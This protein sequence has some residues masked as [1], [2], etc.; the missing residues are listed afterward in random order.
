VTGVHI[1]G[2][3]REGGGTSPRWTTATRP[4]STRYTREFKPGH[5]GR[6]KPAKA[7]E[8]Q[9]WQRFF[10]VGP[11]RPLQMKAYFLSIHTHM[12]PSN[13]KKYKSNWALCKSIANGFLCLLKSHERTSGL[14]L[15]C[16]WKGKGTS[17]SHIMFAG[18]T[19]KS[20]HYV[21][22]Y[23]IQMFF[24]IGWPLQPI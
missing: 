10:P 7:T 6:T 3:T 11:T 24:N 20:S 5:L 12:Y 14:V 8:L 15:R 4:S 16:S 9:A 1:E 19:W 21:H 17:T 22:L 2:R 18:D 13:V 23:H